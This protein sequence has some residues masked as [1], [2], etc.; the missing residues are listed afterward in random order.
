MS[1]I[2]ILHRLLSRD[3]SFAT[4]S[5]L[6]PDFSHSNDLEE[7]AKV[8]VDMNH[9]TYQFTPM[10]PWTSV[11]LIPPSVAA[12]DSMH[13]DGMLEKLYPGA[14]YWPSTA[15]IHKW[16][17]KIIRTKDWDLQYRS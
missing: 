11:K 2:H 13:H 3:E 17:T 15:L 9:G 4:H 12:S 16:V 8:V 1:R 7:V 14:V 5:I 6:S 10:G